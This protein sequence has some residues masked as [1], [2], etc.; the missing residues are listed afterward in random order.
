MQ[1]TDAWAYW[2]RGTAIACRLNQELTDRMIPIHFPHLGGVSPE[3]ISANL[4]QDKTGESVSPPTVS[5]QSAERLAIF[6]QGTK[7]PYIAAVH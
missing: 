7:F 2:L 3:T 6:S 5:T 1:N 4:D